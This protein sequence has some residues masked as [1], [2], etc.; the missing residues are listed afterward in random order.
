MGRVWQV[1]QLPHVGAAWPVAT[2]PLFGGLAISGMR[3]ALGDRDLDPALKTLNTVRVSTP[4]TLNTFWHV[5]GLW[6]RMDQ[7]GRRPA[8]RGGFEANSPRVS[9]KY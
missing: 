6:S 5:S 3:L 8:A 2:L 9:P 4:H 7:C 1:D